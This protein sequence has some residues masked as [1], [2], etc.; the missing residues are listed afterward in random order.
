MAELLRV[1]LSLAVVLG[2]FWGF[3]RV[4]SRRLGGGSRAVVRVVGRR[5]LG[6][7][8]SVAV[9]EVGERVLVVGVSDSGVRLLTELDPEE[10]AQ[11]V[12]PVDGTDEE[13]AAAP[14]GLAG[15]GGS[16]LSGQT[17]RQAWLAVTSRGDAGGPS[18]G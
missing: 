18:H 15:L 8:A 6:R 10:I 5:A 11:P 13:A 4:S 16:V 7:S 17:W 2:L 1:A 14:T 9:V 12:A 3:A